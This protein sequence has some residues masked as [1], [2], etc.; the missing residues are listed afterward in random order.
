MLLAGFLP[1]FWLSHMGGRTP[2]FWVVAFWF[3]VV[4]KITQQ[5]CPMRYVEGCKGCVSSRKDLYLVDTPL[6]C[7]NLSQ[8]RR[9]ILI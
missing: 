8:C 9:P 2:I 5:R 4:F 6:V 7:V 3:S 1:T